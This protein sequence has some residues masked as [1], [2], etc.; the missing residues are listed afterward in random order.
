MLQD[1]LTKPLKGQGDHYPFCSPFGIQYIERSEGEKRR[2]KKKK[3]KCQDLIIR[4]LEI[5]PLPMFKKLHF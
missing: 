1:S 2:G 3:E 4:L 5:N